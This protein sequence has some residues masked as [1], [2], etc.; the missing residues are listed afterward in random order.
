MHRRA[1]IAAITV[2]LD[3]TPHYHAI[4]GLPAPPAGQADPIPPGSACVAN[5]YTSNHD[6]LSDPSLGTFHRIALH[7][8]DTVGIVHA[9]LLRS[10]VVLLPVRTLVFSGGH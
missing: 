7:V 2:D 9:I 1:P 8:V 10:Q 3:T 4:H 5:A 6:R